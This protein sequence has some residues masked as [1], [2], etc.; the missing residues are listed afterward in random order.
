MLTNT[1]TRA[2]FDKLA[3]DRAYIISRDIF[4]PLFVHFCYNILSTEQLRSSRHLIVCLARDARG[5]FIVL[6]TLAANVVGV[7]GPIFSPRTIKYLEL[8]RSLIKAAFID[9]VEDSRGNLKNTWIHEYFSSQC[10]EPKIKNIG[11]QNN[12]ECLRRYLKLVGLFDVDEVVLV[13]TGLSGSIQTAIA[14]LFPQLGQKM[15]GRYLFTARHNNDPM[16]LQKDGYLVCLETNTFGSHAHRDRSHLLHGS[17]IFKE[18]KVIFLFEDLFNGIK[19]PID[20]FVELRDINGMLITKGNSLGL[21]SFNEAVNPEDVDASLKNSR[22]Y[23]RIKLQL[24]RGLR[25]SALQF[26]R[27]MTGDDDFPSEQSARTVLKEYVQNYR[28]SYNEDSKDMDARLL[29][30]LVKR[31]DFSRNQSRYLELWNMI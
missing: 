24:L 12:F 30:F 17:L 27:H 22:V 15:R 28:Q 10:Y 1:K 5:L 6:R 7:D 23:R 13:D 4:G 20:E 3:V 16:R 14:S 21:Q 2:S 18:Q 9:A 31:V 25:D 8:S 26:A 11:G 29:D 19:K